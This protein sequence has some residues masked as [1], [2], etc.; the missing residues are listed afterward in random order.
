MPVQ[1]TSPLES[2]FTLRTLFLSL[3]WGE[4]E[5]KSIDPVDDQVGGQPGDKNV[6]ISE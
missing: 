6:L 3:S 5:G 4:G 1:I 2:L